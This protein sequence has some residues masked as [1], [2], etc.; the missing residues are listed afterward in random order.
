MTA[1]L[2]ALAKAVTRLTVEKKTTPTDYKITTG[3][4]GLLL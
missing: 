3:V 4:F 2:I 1:N